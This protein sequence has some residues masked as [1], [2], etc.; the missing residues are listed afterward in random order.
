M[1]QQI[2]QT[3]LFSQS[4]SEVWE[5]LTRPELI[6]LWLMK[7]DF[8]PVKGHKF[9]F[10]FTAKPNS[11]YEGVVHCEVLEVKPYTLLSY[12]WNGSTQDKSRT[13]NS[14]VVWTLIPKNDGTE[15]QLQH[16]GF[17]VLGDIMAHTNGWASCVKKMEAHINVVKQ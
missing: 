6:E 14:T 5:Y 2:K 7:S 12:S 15:L 3:W 16:D 4:P 1:Q 8:Q 9:R 10:S 11:E 17:T 13:Y